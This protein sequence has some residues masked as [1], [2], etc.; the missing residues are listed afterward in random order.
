MRPAGQTPLQHREQLVHGHRHR[1]HHHQA[2]KRQA[3]LHAAAG[4]HQQVADALVAG[5]H[6]AHRRA[7]KRQRDGHLQRAEEVGHRARQPHLDQ[8]VPA[9]GA[10]H[11]QHVLQLGLQG[12]Q[13]GGDVDRDREEADQEGSQHRRPH[14]DAEPH[15]QN[16]HEGGLGQG[17]EAGHQRVDGG[18]GQ[19]AAADQKAQQHAHHDG[20]AEAGHRHPVGAPGMLGDLALELDQLLGDAQRAWEDE[21][22]DIQRR[23]HPLPQQQ[24]G[25]QQDP[26]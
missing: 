2:G 14:A 15:H 8:H 20:D 1:P 13:A 11:P 5:G 26:G 10:Q 25:H 6:L 19:P 3:H 18:I 22:A 17:V 9:P 12:G 24:R 7:H 4:T 16:G 23:A 21:L